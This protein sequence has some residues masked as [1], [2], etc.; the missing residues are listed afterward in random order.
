MNLTAGEINLVV[1]E[2]ERALTGTFFQKLLKT[3]EDEWVFVFRKMERK[4][5]L[6]ITLSPKN[7][8]AHLISGPPKENIEMGAF[9]RALK[10]LALRAPLS[11]VSQ[12]G[13][14]RI[15]RLDFGAKGGRVSIMAELM[16]SSGNMFLLDEGERVV[17]LA[18]P[19]KSRVSQGGFYTPPSPPSGAI[20]EVKEKPSLPGGLFP[21]SVM[22]EE[23]YADSVLRERRER[24]KTRALAPLRGEIKRNKKRRSSLSKER[25]ELSRHADDKK[26]GD[27]LQ[28]GF[29]LIKKGEARVTVPD[30]FSGEGGDVTIE[31]DPALTPAENIR[32]YYKRYKKYEKGLPRIDAE[33][34]SLSAKDDEIRKK[35]AKIEAAQTVDAVSGMAPESAGP[36]RKTAKERKKQTSGPR[37]FVSS[38]G[39]VIL[40]GRSDR[41]NDEITFKTANG[42]DLWLHAR[43]Y[44]GSHVVARLPKAK[45]ADIPRATLKEAAMLALRYS[46]AAK[47]GKGEVT[48]CRVKDVRKPKGAPPGKVM[49]TGA[50]SVMVKIY[51]E[52]VRAMKERAEAHEE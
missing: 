37:R 39:H 28:A 34:A 33:L 31:L 41:E 2:L 6:V 35:I 29:Y 18:L 51:D 47:A 19:R 42:R 7:S 16:G 22:L 26:L 38:E 43:D 10:K 36:E 9:G 4:L 15:I 14:D 5:F 32:R 49:V 52:V 23:K 46:K 24:L 13:G 8:R 40:V 30:V 1:E 21:Y 25:Q 50:K 48:Y 44:P 11:K 20:A 45:G 17:A 3:S 27:S 12:P